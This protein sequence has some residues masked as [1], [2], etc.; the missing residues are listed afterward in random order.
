MAIRN[1]RLGKV[2][3]FRYGSYEDF[4]SKGQKTRRGGGFHPY[5]IKI[6]TTFY[7][8]NISDVLKRHK[9][10]AFKTVNCKSKV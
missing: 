10:K 9:V 3:K 2:K 4:L 7:T 1:Q 6:N 8:L 5:R